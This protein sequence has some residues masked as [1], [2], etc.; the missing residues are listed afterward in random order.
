MLGMQDLEWGK[1]LGLATTWPQAA[2]IVP[3]Q[4]TMFD[5]QGTRPLRLPREDL[6]IYEMH[7]RGFTQSP[8]SATSCPGAARVFY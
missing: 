2:G 3:S 5:W 6:I 1:V 4:Q 7:V 8:T